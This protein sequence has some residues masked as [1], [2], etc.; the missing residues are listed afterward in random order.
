MCKIIAF[1]PWEV[2]MVGLDAWVGLISYTN[3]TINNDMIFGINTRSINK[4]VKIPKPF[5]FPSPPLFLGNSLVA[6]F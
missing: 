2:W 1:R 5:S 3:K 4:V 6:V